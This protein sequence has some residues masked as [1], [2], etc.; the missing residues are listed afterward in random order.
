MSFKFLEDGYFNMTHAAK[1]FGKEM[2]SFNR[3]PST[4][5]YM[6]ALSKGVNISP[7]DLVE[8]QAGRY[9]GTWAHPKLAVFFARWLDVKFNRRNFPPVTN[10]RLV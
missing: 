2:K 4:I 9:G 3:L 10:T 6:E 7:L 1:A 5:E 8:S